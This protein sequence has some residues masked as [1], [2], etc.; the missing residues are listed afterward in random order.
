M[1]AEMF[2]HQTKRKKDKFFPR[3]KKAD[4]YNTNKD[5]SNAFR[6]LFLSVWLLCR[7]QLYRNS[8]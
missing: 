4:D 8:Q 1:F 6:Y 3:K 2:Y 7:L 5:Y